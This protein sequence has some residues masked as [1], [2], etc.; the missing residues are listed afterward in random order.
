MID[1][2]TGKQTATWPLKGA[3]GNFP[4][5]LDESTRRIL[6]AFRAPAKLGAFSTADGQSV[7]QVDLC[8]DADD[9]FVDAGRRRA[10]V[11]CGQGFI[12]VFDTGMPNTVVSRAFRP[13]PVRA[14]RTS[15]RPPADF[16]SPC[17]RPPPNPRRS[18]C[19]VRCLER[20]G[21][22]LVRVRLQPIAPRTD[23]SASTRVQ[24]TGISPESRRT[25]IMRI[26]KI[27]AACGAVLSTIAA[28]DA[29]GIDWAKIDGIFGRTGSGRRHRPSV[30]LSRA[31]ISRSRSTA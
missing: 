23:E 15:S 9:V 29:Q 10:Y 20:P 8:G 13:C 11:S 6:V 28:A 21:T 30:R 24:Q 16:F 31:P 25:V 19:S 1:G 22:T 17:V 3:G 27:A 14:R 26:V 5:A 4:M 18:G 12:D 7:R 2:R